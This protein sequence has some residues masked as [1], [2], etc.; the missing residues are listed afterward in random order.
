MTSDF[1]YSDHVEYVIS[2]VNRRLGLLRRIKYVLPFQARLLF[3]NSVV[4][5]IFDYADLV[6]GD[7][8]NPTIMNDLQIMQNKAARIISDRPF[9]SSATDALTTLKWLNLGQRKH[10]HRC[11]YIFKCV[12]KLSCHSMDLDT[13]KN[14]LGQ[15]EAVIPCSKA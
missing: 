8:N 3:Y 5:P 6:L 10:Y 15:T 2:K 12:N 11:L 7:K 14:K 4:L 9:Y 1:T 13:R